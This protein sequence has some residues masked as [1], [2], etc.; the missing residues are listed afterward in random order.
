MDTP[1]LRDAVQGLIADSVGID[2][3]QVSLKKL[4]GDASN[5]RYWRAHAVGSDVEATFVVME[6]LD[7]R[8]AKVFE[9]AT[10][11]EA[12]SELPFVNVH[13]FLRGLDLPV[14]EI[15]VYDEER[16]LLLLEDLGDVMLESVVRQ[17]DNARVRAL[18]EKAVRMLADMHVRGTQARDETCYAFRQ[19]FN[20]ELL[21]WEFDHYLEYGV[22]EREGETLSSSDRA[23]VRA[24][25]EAVARELDAQPAVLTHRDYHSRN[26]MVRG[27]DIAM[28]DFQDSLLGPAA[29]DLASLLRDSYVTLGEDLID[30]LVAVYLSAA[31]ERDGVERDPEEFR[32]IFDLQSVQ[33]NLKAAGRFV[34][35][36]VKKGNDKFL[37]YIPQTLANVR[38]NMRK[39]EVFHPA[40]DVLS[41]YVPELRD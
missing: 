6:L 39:H 8:P 9:E 16:G 11:L 24:V 38:R 35:I 41:R 15:H 36:D 7:D 10:N 22:E 13:H 27:R 21:V 29:Y 14:P 17:G 4:A 12:P 3:Q 32:R 5:R 20:T 25:F 33:R 26:L 28:I 19:R 30:E 1:Q 40:L 34:F 37:R 31:A 18:Y 23:T 2:A